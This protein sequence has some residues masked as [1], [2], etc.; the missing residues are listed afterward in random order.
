MGGVPDNDRSTST[1]KGANSSQGKVLME[2]ILNLSSVCIFFLFVSCLGFFS[3]RQS[4]KIWTSWAAWHLQLKKRSNYFTF[5]SHDSWWIQ[6]I[7]MIFNSQSRVQS[8]K[9]LKLLRAREQKR[10]R[11]LAL[12]GLFQICTSLI[13]VIV[14]FC[15][16]VHFSILSEFGHNFFLISNKTI[17]SF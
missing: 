6:E 7:V 12:E 4:C 10:N 15:V 16:L 13:F 11:L 17:I 9:Q 2:R 3:L 8:Q 5:G 1:T 14:P